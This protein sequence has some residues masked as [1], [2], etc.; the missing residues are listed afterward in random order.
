[1][2]R[3]FVLGGVLLALALLWGAKLLVFPNTDPCPTCDGGG[4]AACG[5]TGCELGRV[6]C[7]GPCLR[8][9]TPGW[10]TANLPNSA[11]GQLWKPYYNR[12]GSIQWVSQN[13]LGQVMEEV[14]G[15]WKLGG[16]CQVCNGSQRMP[17]PACQAKKPC[18]TC[19]GKGKIRRWF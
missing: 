18:P 15:V 11:P 16:P 8:K 6:A 12:D 5:A 3:E 1:M 14:D 7:T 19:N 10:Q 17:C 2:R 4:A 9:D 13:H